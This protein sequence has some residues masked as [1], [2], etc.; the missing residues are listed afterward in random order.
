MP[1]NE[2]IALAGCP[3]LCDPDC[4]LN[5]DGCHQSH[6][7]VHMRWHDPGWSCGE[8]QR[9]I[10]EAVSAERDRIITLLQAHADRERQASDA[11]PDD[12]GLIGAARAAGVAAL[13]AKGE[14][15]GEGMTP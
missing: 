10:A 6:I 15:G 13:I 7:P 9:A 5:P 2:T 1:E 4:E 8:V 11:F 14:T 3:T 12:P